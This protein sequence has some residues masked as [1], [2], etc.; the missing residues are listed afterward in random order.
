MSGHSRIYSPNSG[1]HNTCK[2]DKNRNRDPTIFSLQP[3]Y[4]LKGSSNSSG[5]LKHML[6]EEFY[7]NIDY[8]K[9]SCP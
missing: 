6:L 7:L 3:K 5:T 4:T 2:D 9:N 1:N 8:E